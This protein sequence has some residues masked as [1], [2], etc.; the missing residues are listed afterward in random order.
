MTKSQQNRK[1]NQII[2]RTILLMVVGFVLLTWGFLKYFFT[3]PTIGY[4]NRIHEFVIENGTIQIILGIGVII[5]GI[6]TYRQR[7]KIIND[8]KNNKKIKNWLKYK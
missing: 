3:S 6:L 5:G 2:N 8:K 1:I 4:S 7:Y